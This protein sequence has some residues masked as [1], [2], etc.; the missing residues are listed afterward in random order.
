[1]HGQPHIRFTQYFLW[2]PRVIFP[3][4][5]EFV[6][7]TWN[8]AGY[9]GVNCRQLLQLYEKCLRS[10]KSY[11]FGCNALDYSRRDVDYYQRPGI[12][13][14]SNT[15]YNACR[16]DAFS[17]GDCL[18]RPIDMVR[19]LDIWLSSADSI[20]HHQL[21]YTKV[22]ASWTSQNLADCHHA[23]CAGLPHSFDT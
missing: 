6:F 3:G 15:D 9:S 14:T 18:I 1:M 20:V 17:R 12:P 2:P 11:E 10:R 21:D 8:L 22:C 23:R 7:P 4:W 13:N 5:M 16:A 19:K